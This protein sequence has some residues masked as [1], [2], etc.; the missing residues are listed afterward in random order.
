MVAGV[1]SGAPC[2]FQSGISSFSALRLQHRAGHDMGA[3]LAALF[4]QAHG[5][6]GGKLLQPDRRRQPRRA[7]AND[8]HIEFHGFPWG[9][10]RGSSS[11]ICNSLSVSAS[12]AFRSWLFAPDQP[13][14]QT[15]AGAK[16][17]RSPIGQDSVGSRRMRNWRGRTR[18]AETLTVLGDDALL[19]IGHGSSRYPEAGA[20]AGR[21]RAT[22]QCRRILP[23]SRNRAAERHALRRRGAGSARPHPSYASC[24]S[25]WRTAIS[26]RVA[27]PRAAA[28]VQCAS[29]PGHAAA[30]C[31]CPAV[32]THAAWPD[33]IARRVL[34]GCDERG[35]DPAATCVVIV[36]HGS[37]RLPGRALA[38]HVKWRGWH[39]GAVRGGDRGVPRGTSADGGRVA[40]PASPCRCRGGISC[41]RRRSYAG[42]CCRR[43]SRPSERRVDRAVVKFTISARSPTRRRWCRLFWTRLRQSERGDN[44]VR[45]CRRI[46][47]R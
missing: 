6:L 36:G 26:A 14:G 8:H 39:D 2:S 5:H 9:V 12:S 25:S 13:P 24:P 16:H 20:D 21:A 35:I 31:C 22:D 43:W 19:L 4:D 38:L 27:V 1:S 37:A 33:L 44:H 42:R 29:A 18:P 40:R 41:R 30:S 23:R 45:V 32:G 47:D 46:H 28:P 17:A 11:A 34:D 3:D 10:A 15:S 7:A